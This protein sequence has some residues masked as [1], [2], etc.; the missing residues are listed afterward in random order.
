MGMIR[1]PDRIETPFFCRDGEIRWRNGKIGREHC[2]AELHQLP[3][4]GPRIL[5]AL[6][7]I[8]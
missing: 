5:E 7:A 3:P 1:I 8:N 2:N 6:E 4:Q